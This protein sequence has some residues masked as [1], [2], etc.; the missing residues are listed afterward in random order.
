MG[1]AGI[2]YQHVD[3]AEGLYRYSHGPAAVLFPAQVA[4]LDDRIYPAAS[5][6]GKQVSQRGCIAIQRDNSRT[7]GAETKTQGAPQPACCSGDDNDLA[8]KITQ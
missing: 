4:D 2:V 3:A 5:Q 8:V 1:D 6:T 7:C